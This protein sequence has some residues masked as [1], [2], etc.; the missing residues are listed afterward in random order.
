MPEGEKKI[1]GV[2]SKGWVESASLVMVGIRVTDLPS[3]ATQT[4]P[5]PGIGIPVLEQTGVRTFDA[6]AFIK[7]TPV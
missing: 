2:S 6:S 4:A 3:I 7:C 5:P 1:G